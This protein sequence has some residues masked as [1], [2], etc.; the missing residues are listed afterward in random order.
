MTNHKPEDRLPPNVIWL[1][2][3]AMFNDISGE[4]VQRGLPLFLSATLGVSKSLIGLIEGLADTTASLLQV[5]SG[6]YSDRWASRKTVAGAGYTMT[7]LAR[8]MLYFAT[9]WVLPLFAKFLDRAGKGIRTAPRDALI[10][11]SVAPEMRG[12]AFGLNRA[13]DPAGAVI[14]ALLAAS[15]LYFWHGSNAVSISGHQ[16]KLLMIIAAVPSVIAALI[17]FIIVRE[18]KRDR[19]MPPPI[20]QIF[21]VGRDKRFRKLLFVVTFFT[22]GLSSDAFLVL[23]AQSLGISIWAIFVIIALFNLVTTLSAYPA[24]ILSDRLSRRAIIRAGW[25]TYALIYLGFAFAT[26]AWH[27]WAL[28]IAYGMFYGLTEGVEKAF[29]ADLV[30]PEERG[31]AFGIYNG[32]VGVAVLPASLIAG[33]LWQYYGPAAPFLFGSVIAIVATLWISTVQELP[34]K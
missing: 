9:T 25:I 8:P 33:L 34:Q 13:L 23:R 31:A 27:I 6:W 4:I 24:G 15:F 17:V 19:K 11:D 22:L 14:G 26:Q 16:W 10:A 30:K 28:Y 7:A 2:L 20:R 21:S 5:V 12:R 29:V 3:A 1:S 18:E 32:A